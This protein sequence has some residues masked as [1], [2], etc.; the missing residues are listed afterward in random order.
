[1]ST[2]AQELG[3]PNW[4]DEEAYPHPDELS[5]NEWRWEFLRR[6]TQYK[7]DFARP[8]EDY[9]LVSKCRHFEDVYKLADPVDPRYSVRDLESLGEKAS[10]DEL[11][12]GYD[13]DEAMKFLDTLERHIY[14][15]PSEIEQ[16]FGH[17][18]TNYQLYFRIDVRRL[19]STQLE[20]IR[21]VAEDTQKSWYRG[22][23][24]TRRPRKQKWPLYLRVLDARSVEV[25]YGTI[26][27]ELLIHQQQTDQA[28]R[29]VIKQA[30]S[31]RDYWP[32]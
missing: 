32:F 25:S 18:L 14:N 26:A 7:N 30:E 21:E 20:K 28:A 29:D 13:F 23:K 31:L 2:T 17:D 6:N 4:R 27:R 24:I 19:L 3:T 12:F 9:L 11:W 10:D 22:K 5:M 8:D 16:R 1:M 15:P